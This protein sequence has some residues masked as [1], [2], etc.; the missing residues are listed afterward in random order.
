MYFNSLAYIFGF[1]PIVI[2]VYFALNKRKCIFAGKIWLVIASL[3]FYGW[4]NVKYVPLLL[5][6]VLI[7]FNYWYF[8]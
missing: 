5:L 8:I 3:V 2:I 1:L 6:Y 4:F 7:N